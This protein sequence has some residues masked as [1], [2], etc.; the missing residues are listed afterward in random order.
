MHVSIRSINKTSL[1]FKCLINIENDTLLFFHCSHQSATRQRH[2]MDKVMN[3]CLF[4]K[5]KDA[6][7]K[8]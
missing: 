2:I 4:K 3:G 8:L 1:C 5:K 6:T 7:K